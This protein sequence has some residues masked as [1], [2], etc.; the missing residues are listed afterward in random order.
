MQSKQEK[1]LN[2]LV[3][4]INH[5]FQLIAEKYNVSETDKKKFFNNTIKNTKKNLQEKKQSFQKMKYVKQENKMVYNVLEGVKKENYIVV[6]TS[7]IDHM[8]DMIIS[9]ILEIVIKLKLE[10]LLLKI[11]NTLL[12]IIIFCILLLEIEY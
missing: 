1:S 8:E 10:I 11:Q 7:T 4:N 2:T 12:I 9:L 6:N 5:Q 3:L